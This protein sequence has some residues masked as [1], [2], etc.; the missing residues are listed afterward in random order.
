MSDDM[1]AP[2][3]N[4][5]DRLRELLRD[6]GWSLPSR[7]DAMTRIHRAARRQR[8]RTAGTATFAV[9]VIAGA[10]AGPLALSSAGAPANIPHNAQPSPQPTIQLPDVVGINVQQA[11]IVVR[12]AVPG[13]R[14]TIRHVK[15]ADPAGTV[16]KESPIACIYVLPG[17]P[18]TLSVAD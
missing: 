18:V 2:D 5:E 15:S 16:V 8:A 1:S 6:P 17:S 7:P 13:A 12:A 10:I 14:I 4:D 9:A 3:F 11:E